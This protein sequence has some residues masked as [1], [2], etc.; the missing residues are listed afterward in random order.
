MT[1]NDSSVNDRRDLIESPNDD[2][3]D[4][5]DDAGTPQ[6]MPAELRMPPEQKGDAVASTPPDAIAS[7][8]SS[9]SQSTNALSSTTSSN[10]TVSQR[11]SYKRSKK[12]SV[13][14]PST[15][16]AVVSTSE[17]PT[18]HKQTR[19]GRDVKPVNR[20]NL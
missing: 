7:R 1:T 17:N 16:S 6:Y 14:K 4:T 20:L 10:V 12:P 15:S 8:W 11:R 13:G 19:S 18:S 2:R 9:E 5:H 3:I